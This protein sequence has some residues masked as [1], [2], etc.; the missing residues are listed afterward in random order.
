MR[1]ALVEAEA[2]ARHGDVPIGAVVLSPDGDVIA[3][4]GNERE[5]L[6]DPTAHAEVVA[7]RRAA[8]VAGQWRLTDCTLVVTLEP[9]TMCAGAVVASRIGHL[10]F[11]AF[12]E[13][14]G[15]VSS[16]WDVVR[17]PRLNHRPAVTAGVLADEC[18]AVLDRFFAERR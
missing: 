2:A 11:G 7:I 6:G 12:D 4:A 8:E 13:K 17:D 9:C 18:A 10:V 5:L 1:L 15:A 14:A 16:L 3:R